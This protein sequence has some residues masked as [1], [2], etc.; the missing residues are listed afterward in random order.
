[1][2]NSEGDITSRLRARP[3]K[4]KRVNDSESEDDRGEPA[5]SNESPSADT[6]WKH[7]DKYYFDD[8]NVVLLAEDT[9]F[10]VHKSVL[11]LHS[12]LFQDMLSLPQSEG[13]GSETM[14][15]CPLVRT[16]DLALHITWLLEAMYNGATTYVLTSH[17]GNSLMT[18]FTQ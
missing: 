13:S 1:M 4:R 15:G 9:I 5:N 6:D 8:G 3:L 10:R 2:S 17:H 7:H 11:T 18:Y 12:G 16:Q 14:D